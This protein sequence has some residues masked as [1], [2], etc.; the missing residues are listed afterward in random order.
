[1]GNPGTEYAQTRHNAGF[2]VI[3]T[4][5]EH[6]AVPFKIRSKFPEIRFGRGEIEG[7]AVILAKPLAYMNRSGPP[8]RALADYY[9]IL[10]REM[11]VVHDDIDLALGRIKIKSKGGHGGH[12]GV[13]SIMETLG[14]DDFGRLR[15]GI[16]RPE[17]ESV[18]D[19]VLGRIR[20]AEKELWGEIL[21]RARA[22][23]VT[24]LCN[25]LSEAMNQF[26]QKRVMF[27]D[28]D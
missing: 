23:V 10:S 11:L 12:K 15:I 17:D 16:G 22:A 27:E 9:G 4:V 13:R 2:M 7:I 24:I 5:A 19:H 28:E 3:D 8:V 1:M 14:R 20:I 18:T 25:G 21:E 26:N 6:Y